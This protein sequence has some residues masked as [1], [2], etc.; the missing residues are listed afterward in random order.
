MHRLFLLELVPV[1]ARHVPRR[2]GEWHNDQLVGWTSAE[3]FGDQGPRAAGSGSNPS[4]KCSTSKN[5]RAARSPKGRR[6]PD[7][8]GGGG[9]KGTAVAEDRSER[10]PGNSPARVKQS[11]KGKG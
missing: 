9:G 7:R 4:E 8:S 5:G 3:V 6:T 2:R 10:S 1:L 11:P